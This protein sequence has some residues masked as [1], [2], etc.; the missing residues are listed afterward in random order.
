M[1]GVS[2]FSYSYELFGDEGDGVVGGECIKL[3]GGYEGDCLHYICGLIQCVYV[4]G[5]DGQFKEVLCLV[6]C[7]FWY[8]SERF[9]ELSYE[10]G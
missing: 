5:G 8:F 9:V 1:G 4:N 7:L 3:A 6:F 10:D 2:V